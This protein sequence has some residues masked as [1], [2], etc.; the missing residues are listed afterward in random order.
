MNVDIFDSPSMRSTHEAWRAGELL[1]LTAT[2]FRL[3]SFL[4]DNARQV[5]S[6]AQILAEVWEN[7]FEGDSNIVEI[8]ISYLRKKVD[9]IDPPLIR[10]VRG[11]G[12]CLREPRS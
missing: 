6:K 10:T 9:H 1:A 7:G 11:V 3:L 2:E 4:A 8:Y 12:Y 5:L